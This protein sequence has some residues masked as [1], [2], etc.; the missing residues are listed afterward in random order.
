VIVM[1]MRQL[2]KRFVNSD[3]HSRRVAEQAEQR[4]RRTDPEPGQRLLEIGCGNG[5][6]AIR[7]ATTLSLDTVGVDVDPDQIHAANTDPARPADVTFLVADATAL[8]FQDG[9]FDLVYSSK[10]THHI[11]NW[12]QA[13][14]EMA[15]VLKPGGQVVYS[16]FVAPFGH[17]LPT[18][19]GVDAEAAANRLEQ[20]HHS[21]SLIHYTARFRKSA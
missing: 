2:E 14:S 8:P 9:E 21:S 5:A 20:A 4:L 17:R 18:R 11:P 7:A 1:K 12:P 19:R 3:R 15:R 16:D 6:A 10:T 13:I